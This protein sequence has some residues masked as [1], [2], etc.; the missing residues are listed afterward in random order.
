M[1][2]NAWSFSWIAGISHFERK[3]LEWKRMGMGMNNGGVSEVCGFAVFGLF[4]VRFCGFWSIFRAV[5]RF[6][7]IFRAVLRFQ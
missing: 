5:L 4:F 2:W 7:P 6:V 1:V 3:Y